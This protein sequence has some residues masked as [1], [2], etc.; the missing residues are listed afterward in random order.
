VWQKAYRGVFQNYKKY[1]SLIFEADQS[2]CARSNPYISKY[3]AFLETFKQLW[4]NEL[5]T[6][7]ASACG[8][9]KRRKAFMAMVQGLGQME[10]RSVLKLPER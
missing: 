8:L 4:Y 10:G 7:S 5:P 1:S 3:K 2:Q 9:F 6:Y